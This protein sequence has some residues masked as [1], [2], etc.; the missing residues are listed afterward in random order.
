MQLFSRGCKYGLRAVCRLARC[1]DGKPMPAASIARSENIPA[2]F[3]EAI[4]VQ[5]RNAGLVSVRHGKLGG[6]T[7]AVAPE[8]LTV[9]EV[10][11]AIDGPLS[12]LE[13]RPGSRGESCEN[14]PGAHAC[15]IGLVLT[16]LRR[17]MEQELEGLTI[18]D[19]CEQARGA[20]ASIM[21]DI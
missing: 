20:A 15:P 18:Q 7:L 16:R 11:R 2:K 21:S 14:C 17:A 5:L 12:M 10:V 3:L 4:L 8:R 6:H 1:R 13:C 9:A 19:A